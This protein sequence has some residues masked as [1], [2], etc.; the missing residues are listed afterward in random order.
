MKINVYYGDVSLKQ[1]I[2]ICYFRNNVKYLTLD[3]R[4]LNVSSTQLLNTIKLKTQII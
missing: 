2:I 1:S 4:E 3:F